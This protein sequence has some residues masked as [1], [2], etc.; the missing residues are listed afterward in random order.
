M[1]VVPQP[2]LVHVAVPLGTLGHVVPHQPQLFV[3]LLVSTQTLPQRTE[4]RVHWKPHVPAQ[5]GIAVGGA[6]QDT[7]HFPQLEVS[8]DRFTH[9]PLQL[10]WVPQSAVQIPA[11]HTVP[12]PQTVP[13][14]PQCLV[15]D[16]RSTQAFPQTV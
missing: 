1:Q 7:P 4:G 13:Q 5:T 2:L 10:V 3:S 14:L 16:W 9:E 12:T 8:V 11:L 15:S 6:L